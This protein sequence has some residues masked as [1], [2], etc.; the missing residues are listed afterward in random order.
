MVRQC[1]TRPILN[2]NIILF[3]LFHDT[4]FGY[5]DKVIFPF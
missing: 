2:K 1:F 4:Y 5:F 3:N